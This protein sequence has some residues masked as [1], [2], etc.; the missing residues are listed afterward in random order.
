MSSSVDDLLLFAQI[1]RLRSITGAAAAVGLP[2]STVSRRLVA[3]ETRLNTSLVLRST[4]KLG[5]TDAG[6]ELFEHAQRIGEEMAHVN[7]W[8]T[9][10]QTVPSGR[11]RVSMPADFA[12]FWLAGA[13]A[14]FHGLYPKIRLDI[15]L[16]PRR[17]DLVAEGLDCAVRIGDLPDSAL[18]ARKL[19]DIAIGLYASPKLLGRSA[20]QHPLPTH[21]SDLLLWPVVETGKSAGTATV[22]RH[23]R[24]TAELP[25]RGDLVV[26]NVGMQLQLMLAGAGAGLLPEV[27]CQADVQAGRLVRLLP[28]WQ[29]RSVPAWVL[30][31]SK[32]LHA[33]TRAFVDHLVLALAG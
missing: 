32:T 14:S 23:G 16:G 12:Q 30:L 6:F 7:A 8:A 24:R 11:L 29:A 17:S 3:L 22:L 5:L 28:Q 1:A 31:P 19:T 2:K 4:R 21:P 13:I 15:D 25:W 10:Q 20:S 27:M 9:R 18:V 26:N 33:R